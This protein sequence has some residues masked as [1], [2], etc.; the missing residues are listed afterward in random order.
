MSER[1]Y[2]EKEVAQIF[3]RA[4]EAQQPALPAR[5]SEGASD[6]LTLSEL[7]DIGREVGLPPELITRA[8]KSLTGKGMPQE[9]MS[10]GLPV[11]VGRT[12]ELERPLTETEW[13][14]LVVD[15]RE[16]FDAR[17]KLS[18]QGPFKQWTNGNL[19]ALLEPTPA[20]QRLRLKTLKGSAVSMMTFG[21][22]MT[23]VT[24]AVM[25]ALYFR[26]APFDATTLWTLFT[27]GIGMLVAGAI[28]VP[29]WARRRRRQMEEIAQRVALMTA[30]D[31]GAGPASDER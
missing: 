14:Q 12:I 10:V 28:Q 23:G 22:G 16:T 18:D 21:L 25:T 6:G 20:G 15:L 13:H 30:S 29:G 7:Q 17:G 31:P 11:G 19:Q 1:R 24:A 27:V 3:E 4:T 5:G 26:A 9:R 2:S 8:A